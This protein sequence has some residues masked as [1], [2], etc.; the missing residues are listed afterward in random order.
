MYILKFN[1]IALPVLFCLALFSQ[2]CFEVVEKLDIHADG[3][4]NFHFTINMSKSRTRVHSIMNMKTINGHPVPTQTEI[5]Q[6]VK[7]IE[8]ILKNSNGISNVVTTMD[9]E[10]YIATVSCSFKKIDD[11][12]AAARKIAIKQKVKAGE[13]ENSYAFNTASAVFTR[14]DN[15]SL[16][17]AYDKLSTADKEV[18]TNA[19]FT[20]VFRF[21]KE[22]KSVSNGAGK[23]SADKK[24]VML[25]ENVLDIVTEKKSIETKITLSK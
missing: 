20:S 8:T 7:E 5:N 22:V 17:G 11:L 24:A 10:N 9:F 23:V 18:F 25:K 3:S 14:F 13:V 1:K 15:F 21:D 19:F 4:G 2:G 16:K 6:K 12:N